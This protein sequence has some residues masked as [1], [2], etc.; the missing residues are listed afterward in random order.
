MGYDLKLVP[1][2]AHDMQ[3]GRNRLNDVGPCAISTG[4][5]SIEYVRRGSGTPLLISHGITGGFD[6]GLSLADTYISGDFEIISVSRFGY[7]G[8]ALP[9]DSSPKMQ[10]DAYKSLISAITDAGYSNSISVSIKWINSDSLNTIK[11]VA[12]SLSDISGVIIP[13]GF[14]ERGVEGKLKVITYCRENNFPVLGICLGMQC[15]YG[16]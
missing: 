2:Y 7:L 10:A 9:G 6:Q 1:T 13:G 14:G 12:D 15:M 5:G 4:Y 11:D 16:D 8:S 3:A